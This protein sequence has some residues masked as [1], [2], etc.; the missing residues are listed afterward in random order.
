MRLGKTIEHLEGR[1]R[2]SKVKGLHRSLARGLHGEN[3]RHR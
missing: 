3:V 1:V 2:S